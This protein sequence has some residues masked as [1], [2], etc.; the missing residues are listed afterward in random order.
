MPSQN[1]Q[2]KNIIIG[3]R[4]TVRVKEKKISVLFSGLKK[5]KQSCNSDITTSTLL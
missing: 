1:I 5:D 4:N 3:N 2:E